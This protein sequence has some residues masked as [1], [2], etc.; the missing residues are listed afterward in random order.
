MNRSIFEAHGGRPPIL[1]VRSPVAAEILGI[2][3]RLLAML[4]KQGV[5]PVV[6]FGRAVVYPVAGLQEMLASYTI[7][8]EDSHGSH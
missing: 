3:E 7:R 6:R 2:S 4:T 8:K 1:A 5:V